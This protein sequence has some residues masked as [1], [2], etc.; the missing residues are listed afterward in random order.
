MSLPSMCIHVF[1]FLFS[2]GSHPAYRSIDMAFRNSGPSRPR[3]ALLL[4]SALSNSNYVPVNVT[5]NDERR[6]RTLVS[7]AVVVDRIDT[8]ARNLP[9]LYRLIEQLRVYNKMHLLQNSLFLE[10]ALMRKGTELL[11][12]DIVTQLFITR[13]FFL[14][15]LVRSCRLTHPC[16]RMSD[17]HRS[18]PLIVQLGHGRSLDHHRPR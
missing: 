12:S 7:P 3:A 11:S 8:A 9:E 10:A 4:L 18:R 14:L 17:S 5:L 1:L 15:L 13:V 6:F 2:N 16:S